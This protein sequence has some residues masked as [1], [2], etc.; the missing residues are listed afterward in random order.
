MSR[1]EFDAREHMEGVA[2]DGNY[3]AMAESPPPPWRYSGER[4]QQEAEINTTRV[5]LGV[6]CADYVYYNHR[7]VPWDLPQS[8]SEK[9]TLLKAVVESLDTGA[10]ASTVTN[11]T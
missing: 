10:I 7:L 3:S 5:R 1:S 8:P 4:L 11:T 6:P 2:D 9:I